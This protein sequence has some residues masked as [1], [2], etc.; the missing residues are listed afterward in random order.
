MTKDM[1]P[2]LGYRLKLAQ[3]ALHRSMEEVLRPLGLSPAQYAA[4]AELNV[5]PDQTNADLAERAFV[6]PQSMLGV[7][8]KLEGSGLVERR[9]DSR[10]G[11][12]QLARLTSDGYAKAEAANAAMMRVEEALE[13]AVFPDTVQNAVDLMD[14][15]QGAMCK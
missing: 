15:L 12:R 10:H 2:L 1:I 9:Q 11:R 4:L 3:H 14:R 8:A 6:T 13:A 7:L 5:R